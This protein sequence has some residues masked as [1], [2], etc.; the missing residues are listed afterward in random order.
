MSKTQTP[1]FATHTD[2]V[3]VALEVM[4]F[5]QLEF[6]QGGL[7]TEP[8]PKVLKD[9]RELGVCEIYIVVERGSPVSVRRVPQHIGGQ[10]F[11]VDQ[12]EN[13]HA[14]ALHTGGPFAGS[15]LI[16]GQVGTVGNNKQS[17]DLYALFRKV[18]Q[19]RF[20]KI[21]SFYVGPEAITMLDNG[22][23]LSATPKAPPLYDL[24]R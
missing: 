18:I 15:H 12:I 21:K 22:A 17:D 14:I 7:F 3:T 11:A 5:R 8:T 10:K 16:A 24:V 20:E 23:R 9:V 19:K 2:L 1:F 6:F 4:A 13:P